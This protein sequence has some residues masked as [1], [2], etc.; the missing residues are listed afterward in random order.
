MYAIILKN[1]SKPALDIP[2]LAFNINNFSTDR[3]VVNYLV[4]PL[5]SSY[6]G[7]STA[8]IRDSIPF[9]KNIDGSL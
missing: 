7:S 5:D 3:S 4:Q 2:Y 8:F 9:M 6:K 1:T